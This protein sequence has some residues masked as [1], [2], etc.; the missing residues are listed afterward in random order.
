ML[1]PSTVLQR[2]LAA[3]L[4]QLGETCVCFQRASALLH[5]LQTDG[6]PAVTVA[7][8]FVPDMDLFT[9]LKTYKSLTGPKAGNRLIL[10]CTET[11]PPPPL[12]E[13]M[14][15]NGADYYMIKPYTAQMLLENIW[16]LY[17]AAAPSPMA[18]VQP[19]VV[20]FL[21]RLGLPMEHISFW[22]IASAVQ[23]GA[24]ASAPLPLK[25][26]YIELSRIYGVSPQGVESGL[27]RMGQV[28]T[29]L[30]VFE[31]TPSSKQLV[32]ALVS[33]FLRETSESRDDTY[34]HAP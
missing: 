20:E 33:A 26:L 13:Q 8:C 10:T 19:A 9:F 22:Y 5:Y 23:L 24:N 4:E 30:G 21:C 1:E 28:L 15:S 6:S 14:L 31:Q 17:T 3:G 29:R 18:G 25:S 32:A 11:Y 27:R 7:D 12:R 2:R 34:A 16:H